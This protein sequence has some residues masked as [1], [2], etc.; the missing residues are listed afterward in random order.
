MMKI[1]II[2]IL[3]VIVGGIF[4]LRYQA[5]SSR[6]SAGEKIFEISKGEGNIAIAEKLKNEGLIS[7]KIYFYYYVKANRAQNKFL[8]GKY[9]LN[10]NMTIPEIVLTMTREENILPGYAKVT[11]PEGWTAKQMSERLSANG[12]DGDGFLKIAQG[13]S[14]DIIAGYDFLKGEKNLEG[15]LFPDTYFFGKD[16]SAEGIVKKMLDNFDRKISAE[17]RNKIK[18]QG[19]T[20]KEIMTM[21]SIV[22]MEVRSEEDRVLVSGLYWNRIKVGQPLQ[23][24][25]TLTY[26]LGVNKKQYSFEDT[27]T[28]SPYNTYLHKG[29][30]PGP[31]G[32]PGLS[33][34]NAAINPKDSPYNYY[35]SDPETGKTIFSKTFEEHVANKAKYGL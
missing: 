28:P 23:S 14:S 27:R 32:N 13:P 21:A 18:G 20:I 31:I 9:S 12:L 15:Y 24:D 35:L 8:P 25:I 7:S 22:E 30:P 5:Y 4:Y 29:L 10:G 19:K 26:I 16:L 6:G 17:T 33:A 1:K 3:A 34:I 2:L 11:F